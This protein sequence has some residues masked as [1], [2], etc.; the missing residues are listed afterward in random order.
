MTIKFPKSNL[1][2]ILPYLSQDSKNALEIQDFSN[3]SLQMEIKHIIDVL[4]VYSPKFTK[5]HDL[6]RKV[7]KDCK[8]L[9]IFTS[10]DDLHTASLLA[11]VY[12]RFWWLEN[13]SF[14]GSEDE[15]MELL[16]IALD[17]L[18][19][20]VSDTFLYY[21]GFVDGIKHTYY[22]TGLAC[23]GV[24]RSCIESRIQKAFYELDKQKDLFLCRTSKSIYM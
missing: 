2:Y 10:L 23:G 7:N 17:S 8:V 9:P 21:F 20:N 13:R 19:K 4:Y 24:S 18:P 11:K 15:F 6:T 12:R 3:P 1:K 16:K 22:E 5:T 14:D